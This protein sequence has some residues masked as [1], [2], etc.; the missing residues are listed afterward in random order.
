M[1]GAACLLPTKQPEQHFFPGDVAASRPT[2]AWPH[3]SLPA[4]LIQLLRR[5]LFCLDYLISNRHSSMLPF[6]E[7]GEYRDCSAG[8]GT[9]DLHA[10]HARALSFLQQEC[11]QG[12]NP[13]AASVLP[14]GC[15]HWLAR[16][17]IISFISLEMLQNSHLGTGEE[18][19]GS[20]F[21]AGFGGGW[22]RPGGPADPRSPCAHHTGAAQTSG[23]LP[24]PAPAKAD[25]KAC[26][27]PG[28]DWSLWPRDELLYIPYPVSHWVY[29]L[30]WQIKDCC[31]EQIYQ[32]LSTLR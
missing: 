20:S 19:I 5:H 12:P 32:R 6:W 16:H 3:R 7:A 22:Q 14:W 23:V 2:G 26:S 27:W 4:A 15:P 25:P 11:S 8:L 24:Y 30:M 9:H 29:F 21:V 28:L 31:K 17:R 10:P 18:A 1:C 13:D